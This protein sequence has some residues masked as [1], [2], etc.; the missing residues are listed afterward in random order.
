M[1]VDEPETPKIYLLEGGANGHSL[2]RP[3]DDI[4][5]DDK[6]EVNRL[7]SD[8][9]EGHQHSSNKDAS[10]TIL[11]SRRLFAF[12][13]YLGYIEEFLLGI[14]KDRYKN[15]MDQQTS[16]LMH[17]HSK[18]KLTAGKR[19]SV[20]DDIK[21]NLSQRLAQAKIHRFLIIITNRTE[22]PKV[23][24]LGRAPNHAT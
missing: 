1:S 7:A 18:D 12:F 14:Y 9:T 19:G 17:E 20:S 11:P 6:S 23:E 16:D 24:N 15:I 3:L 5:G 22:V 13:Q 2:N 4:V 8:G 10:Q 21:T